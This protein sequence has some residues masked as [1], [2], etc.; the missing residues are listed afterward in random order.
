[1]PC[2]FG[3]FSPHFIG[4]LTQGFILH[5]ASFSSADFTW[6]KAFELL[7]WVIVIKIQNICILWRLCVIVQPYINNFNRLYHYKYLAPCKSMPQKSNHDFKEKIS[8]YSCTYTRRH[9]DQ[10][11]FFAVSQCFRM[12]IVVDTHH[13]T[14]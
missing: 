3:H 2:Q 11:P 12:I 13:Y 5:Q 8:S 9:L 4:M 6:G 14:L 7:I 10:K 1:M